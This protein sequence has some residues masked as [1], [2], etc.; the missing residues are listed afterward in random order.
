[1]TVANCEHEAGEVCL[2]LAFLPV[3]QLLQH[4]ELT[5]SMNSLTNVPV[6]I[7]K[8]FLKKK[9]LYISSEH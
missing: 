6:L 3:P 8:Y 7:L 5:T 9:K 1:M 2:S 4:T